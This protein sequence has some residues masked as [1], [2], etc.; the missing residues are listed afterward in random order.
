MEI[1]MRQSI[2]SCI[3]VCSNG[4]HVFI[5]GQKQE[6]TSSFW[7]THAV[8]LTCLGIFATGAVALTG[9]LVPDLSDRQFVLIE[10]GAVLTFF[11]TIGTVAWKVAGS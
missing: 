10:G 9:F 2:A 11:A 7:K 8:A 4:V 5:T 6:E 1:T 3:D